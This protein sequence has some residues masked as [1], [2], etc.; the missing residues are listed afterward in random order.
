[1]A[2]GFFTPIYIHI[3]IYTMIQRIFCKY[4]FSD[5]TLVNTESLH[6]TTDTALVS[7]GRLPPLFFTSAVS[8]K[9]LRK[10]NL[11]ASRPC[12]WCLKESTKKSIAELALLYRTIPILKQG[13]LKSSWSQYSRNLWMAEGRLLRR[14]AST[15]SRMQSLVSRPCWDSQR[16]LASRARLELARTTNK[17]I[18]HP[19]MMKSNIQHQ[20][21]SKS[22]T[23]KP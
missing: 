8:S 4:Y 11:R 9:T 13:I 2:G 10:A 14:K 18:R 7:W 15:M 3:Y 6:G 20:T 16:T 5:W 17:N 19:A 1:M 21:R 22:L 12:L 23:K